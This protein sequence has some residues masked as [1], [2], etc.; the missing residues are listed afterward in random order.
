MGQILILHYVVLLFEGHPKEECHQNNY[1]L[2]QI[3]KREQKVAKKKKQ[4]QNSIT[5]RLAKSFMYLY[6][7]IV[8]C[9]KV[10]IK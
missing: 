6:V 3:V 7:G 8:K 1:K 10:T 9:N 4:Q 2:F 5:S